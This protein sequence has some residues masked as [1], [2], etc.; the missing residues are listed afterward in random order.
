VT[1]S[2]AT[3]GTGVKRD[4][5]IAYALAGC[6]GAIAAIAGLTIWH[7]PA[8]WDLTN[9]AMDGL[10]VLANMLAGGLMVKTRMGG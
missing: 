4:L 1:D 8:Q 2:P 9:K 3:N 5:A 10:F 6:V 7:P